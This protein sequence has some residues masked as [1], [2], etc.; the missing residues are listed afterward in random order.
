MTQEE[1]TKQREILTE[2]HFNFEKGLTRHAFNKTHNRALSDD[3]VQDC[4]LKTWNYLMKGGK[5][6]TMKAFLYHVLNN[7][8]IDEYRKRKTISLDSLI[9]K[10]VE[11]ITP[12]STRILDILDGKKA[13][14]LVN[15]LPETYQKVMRFRYVQGLSLKEISLITG[16]SQN[17]IAVQAHRGLEKLKKIYNA[18]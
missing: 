17:T 12:D 15:S 6:E 8:V 11:P 1:E 10:G 16:Q 13:L 7:L 2:A 4:F 3:L 9:L 18:S 5:I 14:F